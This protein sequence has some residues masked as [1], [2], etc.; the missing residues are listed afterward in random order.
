MLHPLDYQRAFYRQSQNSSA[1]MALC[2]DDY[3]Q[4]LQ[5]FVMRENV[6]WN[7]IQDL[8]LYT[9]FDA[10]LFLDNSFY[11]LMLKNLINNLIPTGVM[12]H[13]IDAYYTKKLT[14]QK[15][16][17]EPKVLNIDD[18][19][20]GFKIWFGA[21]LIAFLTFL[22]EKGMKVRLRKSHRH[23]NA[24]HDN[25]VKSKDDKIENII[26]KHKQ[27][28]WIKVKAVI[29]ITNSLKIKTELKSPNDT[30]IDTQIDTDQNLSA[31]V[32]DQICD[33]KEHDAKN[34]LNLDILEV[35]N[36]EQE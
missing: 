33:K 16:E 20:F 31:A 14:F 17:K 6:A 23:R 19:Q 2:V 3:H 9:A 26:H 25:I 13:L 21:C 11:F 12:N 27:N 24:K 7:Q 29:N 5:S 34:V 1:N 28:N 32:S 35:V 22:L 36:I 8:I 4:N 30:K 18:L 15:T 10:F